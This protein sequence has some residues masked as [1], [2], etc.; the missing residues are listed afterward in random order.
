MGERVSDALLPGQSRAAVQESIQVW[1]QLV[2]IQVTGLVRARLD[3][4]RIWRRE[5]VRVSKRGSDCHL[6]RLGHSPRL[7]RPGADAIRLSISPEDHNLP[8]R[9]PLAPDKRRYQK[10][11]FW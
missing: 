7:D 1:L 9:C 10:S 11:A 5:L 4:S 6:Y 2:V 8:R 3:G